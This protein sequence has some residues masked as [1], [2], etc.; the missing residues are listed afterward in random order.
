MLKINIRLKLV[1]GLFI[2]LLINLCVGFYAF[3]L[4]DQQSRR[5]AQICALSF[6]VV[7]TSLS[8]QVHFKKQ[9]QEWK[10]VLLRGRIAWWQC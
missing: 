7:E 10:N 5:G 8:A 2:V 6:Q 1:L 9:V 4:Y 3:W